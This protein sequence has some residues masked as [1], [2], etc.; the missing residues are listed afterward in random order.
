MLLQTKLAY[1][2]KICCKESILKSSP[3]GNWNQVDLVSISSTFYKK[4]LRHYLCTKKL[5]S[6]NVTKEKL[7]IALLYEKLS[8]KM[9]M[10][11]TLGVNFINGL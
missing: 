11:L 8:N 2:R 7:C 10:K 3:Y 4:L 6:Q 5:Q 1:C 9:L